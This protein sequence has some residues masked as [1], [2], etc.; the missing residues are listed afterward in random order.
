M[1][2]YGG[3]KVINLLTKRKEKRGKKEKKKY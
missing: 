3:K 2:C 1:L